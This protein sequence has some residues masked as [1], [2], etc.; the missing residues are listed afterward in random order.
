MSARV[1]SRGTWRSVVV[2]NRRSGDD[3]PVA[4]ARADGPCPPSRAG[5]SPCGRQWP[6]CMHELRFELRVARSRRCASRRR[7]APRSTGRCSPARCAPR[8]RAG[9]LDVHQAG[10]ADARG[11]RGARGASRPARRRPP[12]T[13]P[14]ARPRRGSATHHVAQAER[15]EHRHRRVRQVDVEALLAAPC[16][17]NQRCDVGRRTPGRAARGSP[18]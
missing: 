11:C 4:V 15:R 14:S 13:G 1:I 7:A 5:S 3:R 17:A 10:A 6:S 18:R 16:R 2:G 9:H 8:A 12:S